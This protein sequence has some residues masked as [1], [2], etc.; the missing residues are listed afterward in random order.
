MDAIRN[1]R[2]DPSEMPAPRRVGRTWLFADGTTIPIVS[3]GA[4]PLDRPEVPEDLSTID[5]DANLEVLEDSL[6]AY[7]DQEVDGGNAEAADLE[8]LAEDIERVRTERTAREEA[9]AENAERI[10]AIRNRVHTPEASDDAEGD[11][12]GDDDEGDDPGDG[13][14][15]EGSGDAGAEAE[16]PELVTAGATRQPNRAAR[17]ASARETARRSGR[18]RV[19]GGGLITLAASADVPGYATGQAMNLTD[20]ARGMHARARALSNGSPRVQVATANVPMEFQITSG[21]SAEAALEVI[22]RA[23]DPGRLNLMDLTAAGGW[24]TPSENSYELFALD[25]STGLFDAPTIGIS[26]GGI[27]VPTY[28]EIDAADGALWVWTE[29][30]DASVALTL[31][32]IDVA[33]NVATITTSEPH[34][35]QAGDTVSITSSLPNLDGPY[36]VATVVDADTFTI[37]TTGVANATD[38]TGSAIRQKGCYRIP[39]PE[40]IDYRL[41]AYGLCLAHGN[42]SD[43]AFPE[44]TRRYVSLVLNAHLHRN[45]ALQIASVISATHSDPVTVTAVGSDSYGEL[46]SALELQIED[47]RSEHKISRN[48]VLEVGLPTW[49]NAMLRS[50]LAMRQ[51]VDLLAVTDAQLAAHFAAR[52][53]RPQF[54]EDFDPL[55]NGAA[56]LVWPA[57]IRFFIY[58]AG[59]IGIGNG[60]SIDLG[61]VR[62]SRLNATNDFT[63]AWS[64]QFWTLFRRGPKG[65]LVTATL[66]TTGVTGCCDTEITVEVPGG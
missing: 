29:D 2:L 39:C 19:P 22:E 61:V 7:F 1:T 10:E 56:A 34:L 47:Y 23:S 26:R 4:T 24:C 38:G 57:S 43:R 46:M 33:A 44:L 51:G 60:G 21:M 35:L 36:I 63:A 3:G 65:R 66:N 49:T 37:A 20:V 27:N 32:D 64:E 9:A 28:I 16:T 31:S 45:S 55:Y 15:P 25:G 40:W 48:V 30:Q 54:L 52:N 58:P 59:S 8:A 42:L 14:D 5:E 18:P 17:R 6:V 50:N 12:D 62:D 53:V 13:D 11:D 41:A